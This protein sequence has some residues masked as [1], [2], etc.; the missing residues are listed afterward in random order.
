MSQCGTSLALKKLW[1]FCT[2]CS[3]DICRTPDKFWVPIVASYL[4]LWTL[5]FFGIYL[6]Y[7]CTH[8]MNT[9]PNIVCENCISFIHHIIACKGCICIFKAKNDKN[10]FLLFC[11]AHCS[12]V[13]HWGHHRTH[14]R[15]RS[16]A[17]NKPYLWLSLSALWSLCSSQYFFR[18]R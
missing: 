14:T 9:L 6:Q 5:E 16:A 11:T 10:T 15:F 2:N 17:C 18:S 7:Q 4:A 13:A 8:V 1:H 3:S 12:F